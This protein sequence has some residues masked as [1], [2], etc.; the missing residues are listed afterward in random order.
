[1][2]LLKNEA[3]ISTSDDNALTLT[4]HRVRA[5]FSAGSEAKFTSIM[6]EHVSSVQLSSRSYPF[7]IGLAALLVI[8]GV[9][10][11]SDHSSNS[12]APAILVIA[13]VVAGIAYFLYKQ[14][15][16]IIASDGGSRIEF[17]TSGMKRETL[18]SFLD[19]IEEAKAKAYDCLE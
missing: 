1:M 6:L 17:S 12:S 9:A 2:I 10:V 19:K 4:T 14:H 3:I 15:T 11:G 8:I 16:C 13:G 5:D 18:I 7:L